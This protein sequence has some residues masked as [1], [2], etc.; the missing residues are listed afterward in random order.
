[1]VTALQDVCFQERLLSDFVGAANDDVTFGQI[2][3]VNIYP[4]ALCQA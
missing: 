1:M 3:S 2:K 4:T